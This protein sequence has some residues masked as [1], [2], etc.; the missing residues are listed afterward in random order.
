MTGIMYIACDNVKGRTTASS[1]MPCVSRHQE[2]MSEDGVS[3]MIEGFDRQHLGGA[4]P[5]RTQ[6]KPASKQPV[7]ALAIDASSSSVTDQ[8]NLQDAEPHAHVQVSTPAQPTGMI[9]L[10]PVLVRQICLHVH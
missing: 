3:S 9:A 4:Q 2:A 6:N 7:K 10:A 1:C 5:R 8:N